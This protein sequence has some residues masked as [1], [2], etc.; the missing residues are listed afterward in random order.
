MAKY[1]LVSDLHLADKP[2]ASCTSSYTADLLDLLRQTVRVARITARVIAVV[3]AGDIF[4]IKAPSRTSHQLVSKVS[5]IIASYPVPVFIVP[6]NHDIRNDRLESLD[7]QPLGVLYRAGALRLEGWAGYDADHQYDL[8]GVPWLQGY[9]EW[10]AREEGDPYSP[11]EAELSRALN[12]YRAVEFQPR[13]FLVVAHAPLYPPG[14]E[15]PYE[16]F[17]AEVWAREMGDSGHVFYGHVHEP[18]GVYEAGGVTFCN[19]GA[20]SRGSL[21]EYNLDRQVG[22]TIWDSDTGE[23]EFVP[24]DAKPASEV[25]R[26]EEKGQVTDMQGRL[27]RFLEDAGQRTFDVLTADTV[28]AHVRGLNAGREFEAVVDDLLEHAENVRN[29][30]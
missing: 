8:Y 20:L 22:C 13:N 24:L 3:W 18:H 2:P 17:P 28:R 27:D 25:F 4:H 15:L 21:H 11:I 12:D 10:A 9:G 7:S 16:Y 29:A 19:N 1:L 26:L 30:K 5:D 23:F 6:G 14:K